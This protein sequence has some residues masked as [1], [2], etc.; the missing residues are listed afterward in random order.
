MFI[1]RWFFYM[2]V[3]LAVALGGL[4]LYAPYNNGPLEVFPGGEMTGPAGT[5]T[6][7]EF[8]KDFGQLDLELRPENPYSVRLNFIYRDGKIYI[9][10]LEGRTWFEYLKA[11]QNVR[12]RFD[13]EIYDAKAVLVTDEAEK[14]GM[15]P[16]RVIYRLELAA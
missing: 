1:V 13:K 8:A 11:N 12:V 15:D 16:A 10:P 7:W 3:L 9:D 6:N 2:V 5:E 14:E 4:Y